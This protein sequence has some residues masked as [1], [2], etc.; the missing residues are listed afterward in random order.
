MNL[1]NLLQL[2]MHRK[3]IGFYRQILKDH[4]KIF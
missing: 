2:Q 4:F 3:S 1:G